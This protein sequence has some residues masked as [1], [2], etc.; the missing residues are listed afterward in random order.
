MLYSYLPTRSLP[1][2]QGKNHSPQSRRLI[3]LLSNKLLTTIILKFKI[4]RVNFYY[5]LNETNPFIAPSDTTS[6][7]NLARN[8][9]THMCKTGGKCLHVYK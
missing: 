6:C 4:C 1:G 2:S 9:I 7:H 3:S 5:F 8:K